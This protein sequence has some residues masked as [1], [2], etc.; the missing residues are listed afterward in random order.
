MIWRMKCWKVRAN[1][2]ACAGG[3][4]SGIRLCNGAGQE[5]HVLMI[6][7]CFVQFMKWPRMMSRAEAQA[8]THTHTHTHIGGLFGDQVKK[9]SLKS[10]F[11]NLRSKDGPLTPLGT[12]ICAAANRGFCNARVLNRWMKRSILPSW[13]LFMIL[14]FPQHPGLK[15]WSQCRSA[16]NLQSL[17]W[18]A[19][20]TSLHLPQ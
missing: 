6:P 19:E 1:V 3:A 13:F 14:G 2:F 12:D 7:G 17:R 18:P 20:S 11:T 8:N 16:F 5:S 15:K 4:L 10:L 9:A